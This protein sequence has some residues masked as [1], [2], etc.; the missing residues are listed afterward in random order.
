[1]GRPRGFLTLP[2]RPAGDWEAWLE[3]IAAID[4][5]GDYLPGGWPK[6][7]AAA[8]LLLDFEGEAH[9][10]LLPLSL[11]VRAARAVLSVAQSRR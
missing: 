6:P 7:V 3:R 5:D 2:Q 1:M 8:K 11:Q 10:T 4:R 9:G